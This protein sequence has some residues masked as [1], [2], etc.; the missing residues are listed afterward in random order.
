MNLEQPLLMN[1]DE[2]PCFLD[3][4][5]NVLKYSIGKDEL[6]SFSP[7]IDFQDYST[8][9]FNGEELENHAINDIGNVKI[10]TP[11][12][13]TITANDQVN[14]FTLYFTTL[15]LV[16]IVTLDKIIQQPKVFG[17]L[18]IISPKDDEP[19]YSS[20]IGIETRG[21]S[22]ER[23]D[24]KSFGFKMLNSLDMDDTC[25]MSFFD[26][27]T[28]NK[29][30]L[31]GM[32]ADK[33][34]CRNKTGFK[35]WGSINGTTDHTSIKSEYVEV[36]H[37]YTY[38]GIYCLN[39]PV[40]GQ[41]LSLSDQSVLIVGKDNTKATKFY[42]FPGHNS[43]TT[44]W[45]KWQQKYPDP[46][47]TLR[48]E[49][50]E[51]LSRVIVEGSDDEFTNSIF[52]LMEEENLIDYFL[53]VNLM[54]G[55]DNLGKNWFFMQKTPE[56]KFL[57]IPWD[58]DATWGR[59]HTSKPTS[60]DEFQQNGLFKRLIEVNPDNFNQKTKNRWFELRQSQFSEATLFDHFSSN[61]TILE[62][63]QVIPL[64][65]N[66]L[67]EDLNLQEEEAY[68]R[69]WTTN[70]LAYLDA[71]F[72][73]DNIPTIHREEGHNKIK[74]TKHELEINGVKNYRE[75]TDAKTDF[76]LKE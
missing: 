52:N 38:L 42:K 55:Y 6:Q 74:S 35:I 46:E 72:T 25:S 19:F 29:W 51:N 73:S 32:P 20:L 28:Q 31:D 10:N 24:K 57:I 64:E 22:S 70:R 27:K 50:F 65:N 63:A 68:I 34:R 18:N 60:F 54:N 17:R 48:W 21:A 3:L 58:L 14:E 44:Y 49:T 11:Y 9:L 33:S 67:E 71:Y 37:N 36:Y 23:F 45:N 5:S 16:Q 43:Q 47:V 8:I 62:K 61:F 75:V 53:F 66:I 69:E 1:L 30:I 4:E 39:E 56:D 15:P 40:T 13:V 12:P 41:F 2:R 76:K 26:M 7:R 59:N